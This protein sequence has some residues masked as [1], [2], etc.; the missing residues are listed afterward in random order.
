MAISINADDKTWV[1]SL[2]TAF[3]TAWATA[4]NMDSAEATRITAGNT[5]AQAVS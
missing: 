1:K 5:A 4:A 3:I 2:F